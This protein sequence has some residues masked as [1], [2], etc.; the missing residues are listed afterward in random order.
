MYLT[1]RKD[2]LAVMESSVPLGT[3]EEIVKPVVE[4]TNSLYTEENPNM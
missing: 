4:E 2:G 3:T 1:S